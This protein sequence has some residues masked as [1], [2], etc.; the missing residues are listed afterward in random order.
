MQHADARDAV[1]EDDVGGVVRSWQW[2]VA[3]KW[4][5]VVCSNVVYFG[6]GIMCCGGGSI[7]VVVTLRRHIVLCMPVYSYIGL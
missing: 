7:V 6:S 2:C 1:Q 4:C 3:C 5:V